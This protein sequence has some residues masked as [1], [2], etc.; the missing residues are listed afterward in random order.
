MGAGGC[1]MSWAELSIPASKTASRCRADERALRATHH[2]RNGQ[3]CRSFDCNRRV[4]SSFHSTTAYLHAHSHEVLRGRGRISTARR[5]LRQPRVLCRRKNQLYRRPR[6]A[7][8]CRRR[9]AVY[10]QVR[11]PLRNPG[12]LQARLPEARRR[13][14]Q[15]VGA[16]R[17]GR[18]R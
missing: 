18:R 13:R 8:T 9:D 2:F 6:L 17:G 7:V 11:S 15:R 1:P 16:Q 12:R 3:T 10:T 5:P 4:S 14:A